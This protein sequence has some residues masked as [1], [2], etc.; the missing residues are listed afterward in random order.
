MPEIVLPSGRTRFRDE[1][2]G[3]AIVLIHGMGLNLELWDEHARALA[4]KYRVIRHDMLGH[5]GSDAP[6]GPWTFGQLARQLLELLGHLKVERPLVV[7][8]SLGGSVAQSFAV[9]YPASLRGLMIVASACG[10][11]AE[12]QAAVKARYET[13]RTEGPAGVAG[14]TIGRWFTPEFQQ[15]H[16]AIVDRW[17]SQILSNSRE[18]YA[19]AYRLFLDTDAQLGERIRGI[20][21]PTFVVTGD[22]DLGQ[23]PRMAKT[24]ADRISGSRTR[25]LSNIAH[26]L[27]IEAS[28]ELVAMIVDFDKAHCR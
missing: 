5:G 22:R 7:G 25:I 2:K 24:M 21:V 20:A 15:H 12:E 26:M 1:G 28:D 9:D 17:K 10:R 3:P 18:S 27:P 23:T 4:G 16:P 6:P 11:T 8:F 19:N 14:G 13:V